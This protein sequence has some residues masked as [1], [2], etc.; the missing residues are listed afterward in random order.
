M[1]ESISRD[2]LQPALF[3]RLIDE[4]PEQTVEAPGD[5]TISKTRLRQ[6]VLRDLRWLLNANAGFGNLAPDGPLAHVRRSVLNFGIRSL[7]GQ[8]VSK[9]ELIDLERTLRQAILDFEP[10]ILADTLRVQALLKGDPLDH[11]NVLEF[12][13]HGQLWAQPFPLDLLLKTDVDLETGL[14][15]LW[16]GSAPVPDRIA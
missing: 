6:S 11:H 3:D 14:I 7:S 10:R 5:R 15:E 12:E 4:H 8:L 9:V 1:A 2:R 16:D 13:I